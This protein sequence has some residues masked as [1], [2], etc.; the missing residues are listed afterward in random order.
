MKV[1]IVPFFLLWYKTKAMRL[2]TVLLVA[3]LIVFVA[4]DISDAARKRGSSR[5]N[6]RGSSRSGSSSGSN[7]RSSGNGGSSSKP[8]TTNNTPIK[9]T[10]VR[11]PVI[12][13]QT[14]LGHRWNMFPKVVI[15]YLFV[16]YTLS[17]APVYRSGYPMYGS[18]VTIPEKRAVRVTKEVQRLLDEEGKNCFGESSEDQSLTLREGIEKNLVELNTVVKYK[19]S[20]KTQAYF[21]DM[22]SLEDINEEG[23]EVTSRARYKTTIVEGTS[24]T[25]VEKKVEGTMITMYETN[26]NKASPT[27]INNKLLATVTSLLAVMQVFGFLY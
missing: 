7:S 14:K 12:I 19:S 16:R 3:F 4:L 27:Y 9:A 10:T 17:K 13:K 25:Q 1:K 5:G 6:K 22:V 2:S 24:C 20:G 11:S 23:F 15:Y 21:N 8:K 18:Y 26:L